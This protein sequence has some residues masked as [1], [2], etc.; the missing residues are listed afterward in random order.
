MIVVLVSKWGDNSS[1]SISADYNP[2]THKVEPL[3]YPPADPKG[4]LV[5][6]YIEFTS[7]ARTPVC[8]K[9]HQYAVI[10]IGETSYCPEHC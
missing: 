1:V 4:G 10:E 2:K 5:S 6:S 3:H 9:C 8:P 7:G